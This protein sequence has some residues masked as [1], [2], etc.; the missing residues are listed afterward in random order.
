MLIN[1]ENIIYNKQQILTFVVL[2]IIIINSINYS[3]N[4]Y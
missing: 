4:I 2:I 1:N 3:N